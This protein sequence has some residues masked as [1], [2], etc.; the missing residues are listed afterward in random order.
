MDNLEYLQQELEKYETLLKEHE[1]KLRNEN[2]QSQRRRLEADIKEIKQRIEQRKQEI[3]AQKNKS[4]HNQTEITPKLSDIPTTGL[5]ASELGADYTPLASMLSK[6][7]FKSANEET[8]RIMLW[9]AQREKQGYLR[10]DDIKN[11]PCR[12]LHTIDQLWLASSNGKFG[13]SIQEQIWIEC[14]GKQDQY[15]WKTM[16]KFFERVEWKIGD[17]F[18]SYDKLCWDL[19]GSRGHLPYPLIAGTHD[20]PVA[21][22]VERPHILYELLPPPLLDDYLRNDHLLRRYLNGLVFD[23]FTLAWR[24]VK[25]NI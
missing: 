25:C 15:D 24:L 3:E 16:V 11:F 4:N 9:V 7:D 21:L 10:G 17:N 8:A 1:Y 5:E 6:R 19:R 22:F 18:V 14:V 23:I 20:L 2:D 13:F 12:D